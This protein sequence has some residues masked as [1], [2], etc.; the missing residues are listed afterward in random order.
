MPGAAIALVAVFLPSFLLIAGTLPFWGA[1][2]RR[3]DA[4]AALRGINAV[5]VG[6]LLA[7]LYDPVF[8]SAIDQPLDLAVALGAFGLLVW[9]TLPPWLVVLVTGLAGAA[10]GYWG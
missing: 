7:A 8:T 9:W 3:E 6:L 1:L 10:V 4:R 2:R 5:L